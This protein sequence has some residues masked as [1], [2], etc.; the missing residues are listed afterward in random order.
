MIKIKIF[1]HFRIFKGFKKTLPSL[2]QLNKDQIKMFIFSLSYIEY[3]L[4]LSIENNLFLFGEFVRVA[5]WKYMSFMKYI[6]ILFETIAF[7]FK[8]ISFMSI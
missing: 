4:V 6:K 7:I 3:F 2:L 8:C 1:Q 5:I